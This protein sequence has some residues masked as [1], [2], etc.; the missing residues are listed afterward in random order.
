MKALFLGLFFTFS[1]CIEAST[2][3]KVAIPEDVYQ[4]YL[5]LLGN[6]KIQE[7]K[8]YGG[9]SSRRDVV[10]VLI[11]FKIIHNL[12]PKY[13]IEV[14][15]YVSYKRMIQ[16]VT[17]GIFDVTGTS[18]WN[19]DVENEKTF[20][21]RSLVTGDEFNVV[22]YGKKSIVEKVKTRE[23]LFKLIPISNPQWSRDWRT[24]NRLGF[25]RVAK[26][27]SWNSIVQ[28]IKKGRSDIT[29]A[30]VSNLSN[31]SIT[32]PGFSLY[33]VKGF[34]VNLN[35]TRHLVFSRRNSH[36]EEFYKDFQKVLNDF[37]ISGE[38]RRAYKESGFLNEKIKKWEKLN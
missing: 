8:N 15:P 38:V 7:V 26:G 33:P 6:R 31:L 22:F 30:P 5:S 36:S 34:K 37:I 29:L 21:S 27:N 16:N 20:K 2:L 14:K 32:V 24:I 11:F 28:M 19:S 9:K 1:F 13:K 35:D 12:K 25:K 23:D 18:V 10:E 17:D 4:D 3:I